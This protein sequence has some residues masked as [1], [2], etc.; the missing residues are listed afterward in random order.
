MGT[1]FWEG[2]GGGAEA[3][4]HGRSIAHT[5]ACGGESVGEGESDCE[6]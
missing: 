4:P 2:A 1:G 3:T 6:S 5:S